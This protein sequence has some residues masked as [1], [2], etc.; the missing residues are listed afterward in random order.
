MPPSHERLTRL[1]ALAER[2]IGGEKENAAMLLNK[3]CLKYGLSLDEIE[4]SDEV[5]IRWFKHKS[6]KMYGQLLSQCMAK[7][8]GTGKSRYQRTHSR[9]NLLGIECT[10]AQ[11]IEIELDY[12]LYSKALEKDIERLFDMFIQK[13]DIFP[14]DGEVSKSGKQ[15]TEEDFML[16]R[17]IAKRT[18]VNQI[19]DGSTE[20]LAGRS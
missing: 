5:T 6:G 2:G 18:R 20:A 16:Y 4:S 7:T 11:S 19:G 9:A 14:P 17:S 15:W 1:K 8:V 10:V 13:N 12:D 3:L